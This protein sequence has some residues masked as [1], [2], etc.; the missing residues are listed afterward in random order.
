MTADDTTGLYDLSPLPQWPP[1]SPAPAPRPLSD[2]TV[3]C[4][5]SN[6]Y[7]RCLPAFIHCFTRYWP[8]QPVI[9]GHYEAGPGALPTGW[10]SVTLGQ[11]EAMTWSMGLRRLLGV[12][13][14]P[15]VLLLLEDYWLSAPVDVEA[16][17]AA[18][19]V[20]LRFPRVGKID[21]SGDRLRFPHSDPAPILAA[22]YVQAIT[23]RAA[24][25][26]EGF[27]NR[28]FLMSYQAALWRTDFLR[29]TLRMDEDPWQSEERGTQRLLDT[30]SW[31][32]G[33]RV[34]PVRYVQALK[35]GKPDL[36]RTDRFPPEVLEE[37]RAVGVLQSWER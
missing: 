15:S 16:V 35:A 13:R 4:L 8:G 30:D 2:T 20:L 14:T 6:R 27:K 18:E 36:L 31:I 9:V 29:D 12:C 17:R 34:P 28:L 33:C 3:L 19:R 24:Y 5:T 25:R 23:R 10:R 1:P 11:Q 26:A 7:V 32:L 21:L 37:L 22:Q